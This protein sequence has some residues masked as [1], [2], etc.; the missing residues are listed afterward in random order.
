MGTDDE[1]R[2]R[3]VDPTMRV[4]VGVANERQHHGAQA[5]Q[6]VGSA[7]KNPSHAS[8]PPRRNN[9]KVKQDRKHEARG[10]HS[11]F[12]DYRWPSVPPV[13][14]RAEPDEPGHN[15]QHTDAQSTGAREQAGR[16]QPETGSHVHRCSHV[17]APGVGGEGPGIVNDGPHG[18]R[19]QQAH[20]G[21]GTREVR[22]GSVPCHGS[23]VALGE[24]W[25]VRASRTDRRTSPEVRTVHRS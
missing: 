14:D 6:S 12:P 15:C 20:H 17:I 10:E 3:G 7:D 22:R 18:D 25:R 19:V 2:G 16:N 21:D 8:E 13:R 23:I 5:G 9:N 1:E 4:E 11:Q 24:A